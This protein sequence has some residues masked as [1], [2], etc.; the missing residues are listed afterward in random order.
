MWAKGVMMESRLSFIHG[1]LVLLL[2]IVVIAVAILW[3]R[4]TESGKQLMGSGPIRMPEIVPSAGREWSEQQYPEQYE[5]DNWKKVTLTAV[6]EAGS[7]GFLGQQRFMDVAGR[8]F[9]RRFSSRF[10]YQPGAPWSP[11]VTLRYLR[12]GET[13]IGRLEAKGLKPNFAYQMKLK[14]LYEHKKAFERI[15]YAGRWRLPGEGTNFSDEDY[16]SCDNKKDVRSYL[17]FDFFVTD[18]RGNA[19]KEFYL[20][21][22]LHVLYNATW[23]GPPPSG[24]TRPIVVEPGRTDSKMYARPVQEVKAQKIYAEAESDAP[25]GNIRPAVG[26]VFLPPG[27]YRAEF[28]LTEESFHGFG[29]AGYWATVM[30]APVEFEIVDRKK[31]PTGKWRRVKRIKTLSL[32]DARLYDISPDEVTV[33]KLI[34]TADKPPGVQFSDTLDLPPGKRYVVCFSVRV[35]G[36]QTVQVIVD[37]GSGF[38]AAPRY[39]T[40]CVEDGEWREFEFE[41]TES[42]AGREARLWLAPRLDGGPTGIRDVSVCRVIEG[43]AEK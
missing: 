20:D 2:L 21:S 31:P 29:D 41:I 23:Q 11:R 14:G 5:E 4:K 43:G 32:S 3:L 34:G 37:G 40:E 8:A 39:E 30:K 13:F 35:E 10:S 33:S 19:T 16:E 38:D 28:E 6:E 24:D 7:E 22:S 17:L 27:H 25:S 9:S 18:A 36:T 15:G 12:R 26:Q 1:V 42:V